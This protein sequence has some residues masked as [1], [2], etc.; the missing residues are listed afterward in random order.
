LTQSGSVHAN[1]G[2]SVDQELPIHDLLINFVMK[3]ELFDQLIGYSG[4]GITVKIGED[5]ALGWGIRL[6]YLASKK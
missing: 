5:V 4:V 3:L 1:Y 6:T 2:I